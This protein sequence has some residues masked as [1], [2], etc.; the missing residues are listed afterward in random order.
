M[1]EPTRRRLPDE[2][3]SI[4][5][6]FCVYDQEGYLIVGMYDDGTPAELFIHI[7]KEGSTVSGLMDA[8]AVLT[9]IAL[10]HGIPL[11]AIARKMRHTHFEPYGD[12]R[13]KEIPKASSLVDYIFNWLLKKFE[14]NQGPSE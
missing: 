6:K 5:H 7:A 2:R 9:S 3:P 13:N 14:K 8:V 12:T 1:T 11:A 4:T 10:Q